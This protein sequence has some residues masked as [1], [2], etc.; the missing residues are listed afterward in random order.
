MVCFQRV[1][2]RSTIDG[3]PETPSLDQSA[4]SAWRTVLWPE[5]SSAAG[6]AS[7]RGAVDSKKRPDKPSRKANGR[8]TLPSVRFCVATTVLDSK[9]RSANVTVDKVTKKPLGWT[10]SFG[11]G[12]PQKAIAFCGAVSLVRL[13]SPTFSA[14]RRQTLTADSATRPGV[15][16]SNE[17]WA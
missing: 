13:H 6:F 16:L 12:T 7:G 1:L 10:L 2:M 9:S 8:H 15:A 14:M 3:Q 17:V 4:C 5:H 11:D